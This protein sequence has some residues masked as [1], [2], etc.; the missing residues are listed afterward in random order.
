MSNKLVYNE[1]SLLQY[2]IMSINAGPAYGQP[3]HH[4]PQLRRPGGP[5]PRRRRQR[6]PLRPRRARGGARRAAGGEREDSERERGL[7]ERTRRDDEPKEKLLGEAKTR[8][9]ERE[10]RAGDGHGVL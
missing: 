5:R 1:V 10:K 8:L 2:L 9:G 4:H 6:H 3:L 7:G